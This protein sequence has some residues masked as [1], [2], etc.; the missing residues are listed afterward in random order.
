MVMKVIDT[1][2]VSTNPK[3]YLRTVHAFHLTIVDL[4]NGEMLCE[5]SLG[6]AQE[7]VDHLGYQSVPGANRMFPSLVAC[8]KYLYLLGGLAETEP[9]KPL[10]DSYRNDPDANKNR[11]EKVS[12]I[13][14]KKIA[15]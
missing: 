8:G 4:G 7:A 12:V 15:V 6:Q 3:P 2:I 11:T 1:G 13:K 14:L 9:L 5:F 10:K